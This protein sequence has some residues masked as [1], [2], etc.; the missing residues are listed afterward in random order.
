MAVDREWRRIGGR[1]AREIAT[2]CDNSFHAGRRLFLA[3]AAAA[4][5]ALLLRGY[6]SMSER[7][8]QTTSG[9][10]AIDPDTA[11]LYSTAAPLEP[12]PG[13]RDARAVWV[14][15]APPTANAALVFLHGH[16]NY[17]TVDEEGRSRVP[18]W[19][20]GDPAARA[21]AAGKQAA[22]IAYGLNRLGETS[23]RIRPV[24]LAP[25][26]SVL[27]NSSFWA[28]EPRGQYV[29]TARLGE[30]LQDCLSRLAAL[31]RPGGG[32]YWTGSTKPADLRRVYLAGHSGAGLPLEEAAGSDLTLP[33]SGIPADLW[34][35]DCT[36]WSE[37][38]RFV[39]FCSAWHSAG[40][41]AAGR[42][43]SSRFV[44]VYRPGT[45]T[46]PVAQTLRATIAKLLR[47]KPNDLVVDHAGGDPVSD[48]AGALRSKPVLFLRTTLAHDSIPTV[49]IPLL[50]DTSG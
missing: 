41:L 45:D 23:P 38:A 12:G 17:V 31:E 16:D 46:E 32:S 42:A 20:A 5:A 8:I 1:R 29:D 50:L 14:H 43:D 47:A 24:A 40:R 48:M 25:E 27:H 15:I 33:K 11:L 30:L 39:D 34:L 22:G 26:D 3:R 6:P 4:S 36:Y 10:C 13:L 49:F 19:A 28:I 9:D 37:T 21:G 7:Q 44:C 18:D 2:F 35:F